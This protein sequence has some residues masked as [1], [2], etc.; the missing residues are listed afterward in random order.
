M[1]NQQT[2]F[3]H[4][5]TYCLKYLPPFKGRTSKE[6]AGILGVDKTSVGRWLKGSTPRDD[7]I[8]A[9][10]DLVGCNS[11]ADLYLP[12]Q[13]F[14]LFAKTLKGTIAY[15]DIR[16]VVQFA[17]IAKHEHLWD[18]CI[19]R[20]QGT[21]FLYT[22]LLTN[23]QQVARSLLRIRDKSK[24]GITFDIH[25]VDTR[26]KPRRIYKY[27]GLLFPIFDSVIFYAEEASFDEPLVMITTYSQV[28]AP[29][30]LVGYM[31]AVGVNPKTQARIPRGSKLVC[32]FR[33]SRPLELS[34]VIEQLGI[35]ETK[36]I[37]K[38]ITDLLFAT[39]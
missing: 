14:L 26:T 35:I 28:K 34:R 13:E 30:T 38:S 4:N 33:D 25:N 3:L 20:L 24:R 39:P 17:S 27:D 5:I 2:D 9:L 21:Y 22:R 12:K 10:A 23:D 36:A 8:T 11:K 29:E 6:K 31:L 37:D 7:H 16:P 32:S 18:E 19:S 1:D 15:D